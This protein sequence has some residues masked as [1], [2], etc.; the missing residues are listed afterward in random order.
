MGYAGSTYIT[1][2]SVKH[3][4]ATAYD[5]YEHLRDKKYFLK[6][7]EFASILLNDDSPEKPVRIIPCDGGPDENPRYEK[8]IDC[9]IQQFIEDNIDAILWPLMHL[10]EALLGHPA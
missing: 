9:A 6:N 2:R 10:D 5:F 7:T 3:T 4:S 8:T 1:I